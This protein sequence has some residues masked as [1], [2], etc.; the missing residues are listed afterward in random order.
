MFRL[1]AMHFSHSATISRGLQ[2]AA[3]NYSKNHGIDVRHGTGPNVKVINNTIIAS[4]EGIYLMHSKAKVNGVVIISPV[5]FKVFIANSREIWPFA[6]N[7]IF[8]TP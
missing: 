7:S 8:L 5:K 4:K 3:L 1:A 6:N 2:R